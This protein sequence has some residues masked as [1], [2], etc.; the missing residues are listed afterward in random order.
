MPIRF[1]DLHVRDLVPTVKY[2]DLAM[3]YLDLSDG[4]KVW[5]GNLRQSC[6]AEEVEAWLGSVG[7]RVAIRCKMVIRGRSG[8]RRG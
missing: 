6:S 2:L 4:C 1:V 3:K 7:Y 8:I 5:L